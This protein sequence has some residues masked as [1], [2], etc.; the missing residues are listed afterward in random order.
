M[1]GQDYLLYLRKSNGRKAVP[2]Q[3]A[4]TTGYINERG[5][6]VAG[7]FKDADRTAFRK[8]DG[9]QP[10]RPDFNRMLA[11]LRSRPGLRVA[12]WHADR[13]TRNS[14][15][16]EELIRVCAAGGHLIETPSGG[17]YDLSTANGRKRFRD[18]AS[19]AIYEVDHGRERVLAGRA[20]VA[21][22]GRWLGG[23]RPFGWE[24]DK[25]PVD[26][27]G[28]PRLDE[29]DHPVRGVLRLRQPEAD[30]LARAHRSVLD[31][32]TC[33][34][35][36]REWNDQ[37]ILTSKGKRW[38][39]A[40]VSRVLR[41]PRN[42]GLMEYQGREAGTADWPA[43][44]DEP[45]WRAVVAL[46][47]DPDRTTTPGPTRK[48][49]LTFIARCG[50]CGGPVIVSMTSGAA[51]R[52]RGRRPVY[53]CRADTRAHVARD[54]AAVDDLITRL[55]IAR[56]SREDAADLLA[57]DRRNELAALNREAKAVEELMAADRRL[58]QE[59]LI[60]E[61]EFASA[62]RKHLADL[63]RITQEIADAG[64]A[65]VLAQMIK[66]DPE[67]SQDQRER[68]VTEKWARLG[69][70]RRRAVV[71]ALMSVVIE[72]APRGRPAGWKPGTSYFDPRSV[73][74]EWRRGR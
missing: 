55:V 27:D 25:D 67:A 12:A 66:D 54:Q 68:L 2:R 50:V 4:I 13:L 44:V 35:I 16:T 10:E 40:E 26:D 33:A 9:D 61:L 3:R 64:Q 65:D 69:L 58:Q 60:S 22:E 49:L 19:A 56:L 39:G 51:E 32:A 6:Q 42:A 23:K 43:V 31:G 52:R 48:H 47:S 15:D 17:T 11:V 1:P 45:T 21:S 72:P 7:E 71:S 30:A 36:A 18:D 20:E 73:R 57:K 14:E 37:G 24:L 34:G 59:S 63:A 38:R 46:L 8:V 29:D 53:R 5:G 70:D 74:I 41:R 62:R 28:N